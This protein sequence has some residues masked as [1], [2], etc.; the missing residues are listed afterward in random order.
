MPNCVFLTVHANSPLLSFMMVPNVQTW[1]FR[2]SPQL[3]HFIRVNHL[4]FF[5]LHNM[6]LVLK[7][8][9]SRNHTPDAGSRINIAVSAD[10]RAGI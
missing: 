10:D 4:S 2:K 3:I 5:L 6:L 8:M 9:T 7:N 1:G